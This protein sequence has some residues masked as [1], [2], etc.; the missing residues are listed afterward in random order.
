M[1][2][3][4][5]PPVPQPYTQAAT[6]AKAAPP[7][8]YLEPVVIIRRS[9]LGDVDRV[10]QDGIGDGHGPPEDGGGH[11]ALPVLGGVLAAEGPEGHH[12][13][14]EQAGAGEGEVGADG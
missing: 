1:T 5:P 14:V 6:M 4:R 11:E 2:P 3:V 8:K 7:K 13:G 9:S 12:R 10:P